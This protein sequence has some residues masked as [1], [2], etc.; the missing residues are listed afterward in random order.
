IFSYKAS[1][2]DLSNIASV[3]IVVNA[4]NNPPV[5]EDISVTLQEDSEIALTLVGYDED[6]PNE[7]LTFEIVDSTSLGTLTLDDRALATYIYIPYP[8]SSGSDSFTYSVS[9][10]ELSDTATVAI[11]IT[12]VNDAPVMAAISDTSTAEDTP[13]DISVVVT[14]IE[15]D[16]VVLEIVGDPQHG[17]AE[18]VPGDS[19]RY[20]PSPGFNGS[21]NIVLQATDSG[22]LSSNQ[23]LISIEV[24]PVNDAPVADSFEIE[25]M[26]DGDITIMLVG[27]DE[28]T[29]D[30]SLTFEI[31]DIPTHGIL[32]TAA[33]ALATYIYTPE[34][35]YNDSDSFTY[36]VSDGALSD[37]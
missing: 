26:E 29:P 6:T 7:N 5:A 25:M 37:T 4:I 31:V 12:P 3:T 20:T 32:D 35:N 10:G 13:L 33:R 17:S 14:D 28:E 22:G 19:V 34:S 23:V 9:D 11:T 30:G 24:T 1:D 21:D 15:N 18:I 8:D 2:G 16:P 36:S 27:Y